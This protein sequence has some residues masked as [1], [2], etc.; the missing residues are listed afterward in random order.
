MPASE[1]PPHGIHV[2]VTFSL[3]TKP[4]EHSYAPTTQ[5]S[6][7]QADALAAF[8]VTIDG[9]TGYELIYDGEAVPP[10]KSV[11]DVARHGN[12]LRLRLCTV[13]ISG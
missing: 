8:K 2:T 9:T 11:G 13:T 4:Y 5:I 10:D 12:Q 1:R 3:A 6:T 7:V